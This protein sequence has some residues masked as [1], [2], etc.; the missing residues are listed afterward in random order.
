MPAAPIVGD[1][2]AADV[3]RQIKAA[4]FRSTVK[5][6]LGASGRFTPPLRA[7]R[8]DDWTREFLTAHPGATVLHLACGLDSRAFRIDAP[9]GVHWYDL[10]HTDVI[11]LRERVYPRRDR[12]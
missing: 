11:E 8:L 2:W 4:A 12:Y 1:P 3:L 10:D 9:D 5:A 7:R 6:R